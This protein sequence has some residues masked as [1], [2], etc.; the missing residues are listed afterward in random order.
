MIAEVE[1]PLY[2]T[3]C[4]T[5]CFYYIMNHS[6]KRFDFIEK[7]VDDGPKAESYATKRPTDTIS[8]DFE[9][10]KYDNT[11]ICDILLYNTT[12]HFSGFVK[13]TIAD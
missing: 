5:K 12:N 13:F 11:D 2:T 10:I 7:Y 6:V 8:I 9:K 3:L 1:K 4:N